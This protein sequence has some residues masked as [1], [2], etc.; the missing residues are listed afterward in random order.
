MVT[1]APTVVSTTD[2]PRADLSP[3]LDAGSVAVIG[4]SQRPGSVGNQVIR[5]L[6]GGG[7]P[8]RILPVNPRYDRVEGI[9]CLDSLALVGPVDLAVLA[10]SNDQLEGSMQDVITNRARSVAIFASC[11]GEASD[12][13]P[14][15]ARLAE[16]ARQAGIPVCGGNGMGFV[17]LDRQLRVTGF[18]Q[19]LELITGGVTFLTHS[20]S[21]F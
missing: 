6:H 12:G 15:A 20:G 4:A 11:F 2:L 13:Q 5:Q 14:L 8:G 21:L 10:L 3:L 18:Y 1:P 9:E 19:P 16:I 17:N 7:F